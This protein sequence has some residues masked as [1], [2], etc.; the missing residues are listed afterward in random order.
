MAVLRAIV[1]QATDWTTNELWDARRD[2]I[3]S[4]TIDSLH[5]KWTERWWVWY[6]QL[7]NRLVTEPQMRCEMIGELRSIVEQASHKARIELNDDRYVTSFS[8]TSD[9]LATNE[10]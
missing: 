6:E 3:Y 7:W 8:E 2:T 5:H 1:K 10:L 9:P 4:G